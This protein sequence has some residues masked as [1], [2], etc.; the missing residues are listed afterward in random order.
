M[1]TR[2]RIVIAENERE[3]SNA[4]IQ[5][6]HGVGY[7]VV[8]VTNGLKAIQSMYPPPR[9]P[10]CLSSI[11]SYLGTPDA[12]DTA[13]QVL[14][15]RDIPVLFLTGDTAPE[16]IQRTHTIHRYG[17]LPIACDI[18]LFLETVHTAFD[19]YDQHDQLKQLR[20]LYSSIATLTGDII[21]RYDATGEC[22]YLNQAGRTLLGITDDL[23][24]K[25][26]TLALQLSHVEAIPRHHRI[27]HGG[28]KVVTDLPRRTHLL[29]ELRTDRGLPRKPLSAYKP[30]V[31][32]ITEREETPPRDRRTRPS[33][34]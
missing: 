19:L 20:D 6:L 21:A 10:I 17:I 25:N 33:T 18:T 31:E 27:D 28:G 12:I 26:P 8:P 5:A 32:D 11:F 15:A 24:Y 2:E 7:E 13:Q 3:R 30:P 9:R 22:V 23:F 16:V 1:S 29:V 34:R 4:H 14:A